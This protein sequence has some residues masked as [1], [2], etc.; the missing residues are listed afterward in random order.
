[1]DCAIPAHLRCWNCG[2]RG[3]PAVGTRMYCPDCEVEWMPHATSTLNS[4]A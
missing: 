2:Q 4:P 3:V 1:M